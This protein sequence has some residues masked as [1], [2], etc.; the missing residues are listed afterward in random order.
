MPI[1]SV[2]TPKQ[3]S[4]PPHAFRLAPRWESWDMVASAPGNRSVKAGQ[5]DAALHMGMYRG[6]QIIFQIFHSC[7]DA[8]VSHLW[9]FCR[10]LALTSSY[11]LW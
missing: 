5:G 3:I 9:T 1:T 7:S 8:S 2:L 11:R 10:R 4:R 6:L